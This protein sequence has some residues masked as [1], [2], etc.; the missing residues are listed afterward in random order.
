MDAYKP[1]SSTFSNWSF[2]SGRGA[3]EEMKGGGLIFFC[4]LQRGLEIV[5]MKRWEE[6]GVKTQN[7][8]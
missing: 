6:A 3:W 8:F 2:V 1:L 7:Y 5:L 4:H